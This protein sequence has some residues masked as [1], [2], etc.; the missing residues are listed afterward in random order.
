MSRLKNENP[1]AKLVFIA[2][3]DIKPEIVDC[4]KN[5]AKRLGVSLVELSGI[6]KQ[7]G[8]PTP[9]G[10]KQILEQVIKAFN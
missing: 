4:M 7:K 6:E 1:D 3:C 9:E 10:M 2:N 5:A 8:H